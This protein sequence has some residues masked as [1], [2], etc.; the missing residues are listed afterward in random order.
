MIC[1]AGSYEYVCT[2]ACDRG[3]IYMMPSRSVTSIFAIE[4]GSMVSAVT[5]ALPAGH[6]GAVATHRAYI[7]AH[8]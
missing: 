6:T 1:L 3:K 2:R 8:T 4:T 5:C 7:L